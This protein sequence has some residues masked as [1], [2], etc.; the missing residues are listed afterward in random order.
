MTRIALVVPGGVDRSGEYRVIPALLAL[1]RRLAA[2]ND[3]QVFALHQEPE[4]GSWDLL[5]ARVHN[6]GRRWTR[7]RAVHAICSEHGRNSFDVI[8][9]IWSGAPGLVAVAAA[10][11]LRV[12]C[13]IHVA[14]GELAALPDIAYGG[15][16]RWRGRLRERLV[17]GLASS[18]T[19]ASVPIIE[20]LSRLG[21]KPHRVALGV[22]LD[23]WPRRDP[24]VR[25]P[26]QPLRL[27]HVA[28]LNRVKDQPTLLRALA[29]LERSG[30]G[31]ELDIVGE[32]T[33]HGEIQQ[34]AR[35]LGLAEKIRFHG[36]LP[37]SRLRP[38][39]EAA[40]LMVL[41]SRHEAGPIAMLEAALAG[42]PTVGTLVGHIAEWAPNAALGVPVGDAA[43]LAGAISQLAGDEDRRMAIARM[44]MHR[45]IGEDAEYTAAQ[46]QALYA[47]L[48]DSGPLR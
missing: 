21:L 7:S 25:L 32:D 27:I 29:L 47:R 2:V 44:A 14:G 41:T 15:A 38:L 35:D 1:I 23:T 12:P 36:F 11:I 28:S 22:D 24:V 48:I 10:R 33:L 26:G 31:V 30:P 18:V 40:H 19:A 3:V 6:I 9:A 8:H 39:V 45:A 20:S 5:G 34:L 46:F 16:L 43:A 42:V 37:Q 4:V 13:L 17:L